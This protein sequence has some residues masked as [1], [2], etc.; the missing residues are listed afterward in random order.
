MTIAS[1][2][3]S[4]PASASSHPTVEGATASFR[5]RLRRLRG[6][7]WLSAGTVAVAL[8]ALGVGAAGQRVATINDRVSIGVGNGCITCGVH[9]ALPADWNQPIS[10]PYWGPVGVFTG[11]V[12]MDGGAWRPYHAAGWGAHHLVVPLW[13]PLLAGGLLVG[14]T[15]GYLRGLG[16]RDPS[17]CIACGHTMRVVAGASACP[18]CGVLQTTGDAP[19][20]TR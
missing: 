3:A 7:R 20:E 8:A 16:R 12:S 14:L 11:Y 9:R 1:P 15:H 5:H 13:L 6:L 4:P 17:T 2:T 19:R 18:E 10:R